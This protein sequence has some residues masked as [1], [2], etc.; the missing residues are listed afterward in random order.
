MPADTFTVDIVA[1]D[2]VVL[3]EEATSLVAPGALGSLGVLPNHAPLLAELGIGEVRLRNIDGEE[4]RV[5]IQGGFLQ[6]G[7]NQVT[8]L[9]DAAE[10]AEDI[11]VARARLACA[12]AEEAYRRAS[13]TFDEAQRD[14][15]E[16]AL[17]RARNRLR[18]AGVLP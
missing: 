18:V 11:D 17:R 8:I 10:R 9:A 1:P 3:H 4:H 12:E 5:A 13:A 7:G 14:E 16:A 15:A 6:V 2:R